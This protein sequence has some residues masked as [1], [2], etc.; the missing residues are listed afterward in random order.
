M[1]LAVWRLE[2][3][4]CN[5][6]HQPY[7]LLHQYTILHSLPESEQKVTEDRGLQQENTLL[8]QTNGKGELFIIIVLGKNI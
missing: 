4:T 5:K 7:T 6:Q 3:N 8:D 1:I 2:R